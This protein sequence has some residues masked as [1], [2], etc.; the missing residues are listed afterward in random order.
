MFHI[1]NLF[2]A[3]SFIAYGVSCLAAAHMVREFE[4]FGLPNYRKLTGIL[5]LLG[6]V[7]LLIGF[8]FPII[9]ALAAGGLALQ[10]LIGFGVRLKIRDHFL[11]SLPAF[12]YLLINAWLCVQFFGQIVK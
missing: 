1:L 5:Q 6:A 3:L 7:G 12:A 10:M 8:R 2:C 9:G 11:Q 4:R